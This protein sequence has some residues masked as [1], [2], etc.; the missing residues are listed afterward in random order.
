MAR[1]FSPV[2]MLLTI[3][4]AASPAVYAAS[5]ARDYTLRGK[6][7]AGAVDHVQTKIEVGGDLTVVEDAKLRRLKM[8]VVGNLAY[9][10]RSL[11]IPTQPDRP[12][13]SIRQYNAAS[14]TIKI[15]DSSFTPALAGDRTLVGVQVDDSGSTL[16]CP[17]G[18][19]TR[20]ELDLIDIQGNT[21]L[22][23]RLLPDQAVAVGS[24]WKHS[25]QLMAALLRLDEVGKTAVQSKLVSVKDDAALIEMAGQVE[26]AILGVSTTIELKGKYQFHIQAGRVT[27]IS[28]L[29]K[30]NRSIG[31]AGTGLDVV[32]RVQ[33]TVTPGAAPGSLSDKA[34]TGVPLR[35]APELTQLIH[36]SPDDGWEF[37]YDRRWFITAESAEGLALRMIDRGELIAQCNVA[38]V[39]K[40][41]T[42][43]PVGLD[44]FQKDIQRALGERFGQFVKASQRSNDA[45]YRIYRVEAQGKVEELP[46]LW[47]YHLV[48]HA[49]GRR[50]SF[51]FTMEG[52]LF[53]QF[54]GADE[55]MVGT[56]RFA[57]RSVADQAPAQAAPK[58]AAVS[59]RPADANP[60]R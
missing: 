31:H 56:V 8:S 41:D 46:I 22:L 28:L 6:R 50:V 17:H 2:C 5:Q 43:K 47:I 18:P 55:S 23:E 7:A 1:L 57:E 44:A 39:E 30:E 60:L 51:A 58:P 35:P 14:A 37:Y 10:E 16:F 59:R 48:M 4:N 11:E 52:E 32:A 42:S 33:T 49:D 29:I 9:L 34:L 27:W 20:E 25:G 13:R 12:R 40:A 3:L 38:A 15:E 24:N 36:R 21:V 53:D 26:G 19:L 54:Q 45:G